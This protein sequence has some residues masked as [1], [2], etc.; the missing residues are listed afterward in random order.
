MWDL[1]YIHFADILPPVVF[2]IK[3]REGGADGKIAK[4]KV[5]Y[6]TLIM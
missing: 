2:Y 1:C 3:P 6:C 5:Y 4:I